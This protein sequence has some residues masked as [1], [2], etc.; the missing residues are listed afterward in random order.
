[1]NT[2]L[3]EI[4]YSLYDYLFKEWI[5]LIGIIIFIGL[6]LYYIT[7]NKQ[8]FDE[9]DINFVED[10]KDNPKINKTFMKYCKDIV[11]THKDK[12]NL[13]D[14]IIHYLV[15][16]LIL[17]LLYFIYAG[18]NTYFVIPIIMENS[19]CGM[20]WSLLR[21]IFK[22]PLLGFLFNKNRNLTDIIDFK[23]LG[24]ISKQFKLTIYMTTI[25]L[26]LIYVVISIYVI[27]EFKN[28]SNNC[29]ILRNYEKLKYDPDNDSIKKKINSDIVK[30]HSIYYKNI[31]MVIVLIILYG[32]NSDIFFN[33]ASLFIA[34]KENIET[35]SNKLKNTDCIVI[36]S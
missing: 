7:G 34:S 21:F 26:Y 4:F 17:L 36:K 19:R 9:L 6:F 23:L 10:N 35:I 20:A 12:I 29:Y 16:I 3:N 5:K 11:S 2:D 24:F 22:W 8:L 31:A 32:F 15:V 30:Y 27:H 1:M 25:L 14:D 28:N 33:F 13:Y 18:F